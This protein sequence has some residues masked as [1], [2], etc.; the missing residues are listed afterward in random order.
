MKKLT[1][2]LTAGAMLALAACKKST[3]TTT[4]STTTT[5]ST[6]TTF[7]GS[8]FQVSVNGKNFKEKDAQVSNSYGHLVT[9][10][11]SLM[12]WAQQNGSTTKRIMITVFDPYAVYGLGGNPAAFSVFAYGNGTGSFPMFVKGATPS[13][14]YQANPATTYYD[15][16]GTMNISHNGSDYLEG[17]FSANLYSSGSIYPATG[18]FK[19]FH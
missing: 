2:T 5:S 13:W 18:S 10:S 11:S 6:D 15:T 1:I 14:I 12:D 4:T 19:I 7:N 17:T 3:S 9:I 8:Y 16:T